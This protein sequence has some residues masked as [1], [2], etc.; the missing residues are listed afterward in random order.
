M[1]NWSFTTEQIHAELDLLSLEY[2]TIN[3]RVC[4]QPC[5]LICANVENEYG[6]RL[7]AFFVVDDEADGISLLF[8][9]GADCLPIYDREYIREADAVVS[10]DYPALRIT[11]QANGDVHIKSKCAIF[12]DVPGANISACAVDFLKLVR[13]QLYLA[14]MRTYLNNRLVCIYNTRGAGRNYRPL[15]CYVFCSQNVR[16]SIGKH[17]PRISSFQGR[18]SMPWHRFIFPSS[19]M[20]QWSCSSHSGLLP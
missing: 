20:C 8:R 14:Y 10:L 19:S 9:Y 12:S 7:T 18:S 15:W 6:P 16:Q 13:R 3:I 2:D 4:H 5:E 17:Y 1:K 11:L